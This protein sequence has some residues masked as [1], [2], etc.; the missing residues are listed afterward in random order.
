MGL[1]GINRSLY[2]LVLLLPFNVFKLKRYDK[3]S[4]VNF[5]S[6]VHLRFQMS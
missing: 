6:G 3:T 4:I 1:V 2:E 5:S